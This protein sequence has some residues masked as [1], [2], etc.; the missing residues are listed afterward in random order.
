MDGRAI[1]F[2]ENI[3]FEFFGIGSLQ[4]VVNSFEHSF[5]CVNS[6]LVNSEG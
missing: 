4:C 1:S 5:N 3:C 6:E 2:S